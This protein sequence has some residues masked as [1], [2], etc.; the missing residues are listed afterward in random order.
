[1]VDSTLR[2]LGNCDVGRWGERECDIFVRERHPYFGR[3]QDFEHGT[4]SRR[5]KFSGNSLH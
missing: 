4:R 5:L 2:P 1:V 3:M